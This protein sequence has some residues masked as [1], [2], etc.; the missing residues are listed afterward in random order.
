MRGLLNTIRRRII[1]WCD[2]TQRIKTDPDAAEG[3]GGGRDPQPAVTMTGGRSLRA[4]LDARDAWIN[5]SSLANVP[6]PTFFLGA[7]IAS[8]Q[9]NT[10][11]VLFG[12]SV[13]SHHVYLVD[14]PGRMQGKKPRLR[15]ADNQTVPTAKALPGPARCRSRWTALNLS[16]DG[17][18]CLP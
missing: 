7:T 6:N 12:S 17:K 3:R 5:A 10:L 16:C 14:D 9:A 2:D 11:S 8:E 18:G 4:A 15:K 1:C 13:Y